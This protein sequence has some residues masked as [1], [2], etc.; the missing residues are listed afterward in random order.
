MVSLVN[1]VN[2]ILDAA[3]EAWEPKE[4]GPTSDWVVSHVRLSTEFEAEPGHY[5]LEDNPFWKEVIDCFF[6][7]SVK[8]ITNMKSTQVGG[9]LNAIALIL[10]ASVIDP[11][12]GMVVVPTQDEAKL[13]RDRIY[14]NA[15]ASDPILAKKVPPERLRNLQSIDLMTCQTYLAWAGSRQRLRGKPC[16]WVWMSEIDVYESVGEAG[17][18]ARTAERRT[19]Q[20]PGSTILRESTPVGDESP[21]ASF[22][23][24][25]DRRQW[26]AKCPHCGLMQVP[27]FFTYKA[28][29][30]I[31]RGGVTGYLDSKGQPLEPEI[32]RRNAKYLCLSGCEIDSS[33]KNLFIRNGRWLPEGQSIDADGNIV[34]TAARDSRHRGYHIWQAFN[35]KKT[36]GDL[37]ET[38]LAHQRDGLIREFFQDV[39]GLRFRSA[40]NLPEWSKV[41]RR[42]AGKH[43]QGYCPSDVWFLTAGCDVQE[44]R[45]YFT[46]RGWGPGRNSW[47][48]DWGEFMRDPDELGNEDEPQLDLSETPTLLAS[49]LRQ[50][51]ELLNRQY[52][53]TGTNPLGRQTLPIRL[54]GVDANYRTADVHDY[55]ASRCSDRLRAVRGDHQI[56]PREKYRFNVIEKNSRTGKPYE[57][58]FGVWGL[59]VD[60]Y[61]QLMID[62][63]RGSRDAVGSYW[64]PDD[65]A[66]IGSKYLRQLVNEPPTTVVDHKTGRKKT[67]FKP[68]SGSI[69]VDYWDTT[70][71]A[72]A[73]ADMVV[74]QLGWSAAAWITWKNNSQAA[75]DKRSEVKQEKRIL[76]R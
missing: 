12:P 32:A 54:I 76:E 37:A 58:G 53:V 10:A 15:I 70:N 33:E 48:I 4:W 74:D 56:G 23:D 42:L 35:S 41:G 66:R 22:Y 8:S 68:K 47:L 2:L 19:D 13:T 59:K 27:R 31:G 43:L 9:T 62:R 51:D 11:A 26:W 14:A 50:I 57:N 3:V 61:K 17:D 7:P 18:Q 63:I 29:D 5:N 16:K 21:I 24:S 46:V 1:P 44:D 6:D 64:L 60:V 65:M 40:K 45:V 34:G 20:F 52:P 67:I 69:G 25:S 55:I 71:Y 28:G 36:W 75:K 30:Y 49:D 72:E 73:M 39:L 38:Y